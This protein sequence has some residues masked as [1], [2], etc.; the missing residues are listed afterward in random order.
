MKR[1]KGV[2]ILLILLFTACGIEK[3]KGKEKEIEKLK[4]K[5]ATNNYKYNLVIPQISNVQSEDISYFNLSLQENARLII[6]ELL[7]S[8]EDLKQSTPYEA[9]MSYEVKENSF[10]IT[11][12]LLKIYTYTGGAHGNTTL[13]TYNIGDKDLKL[14]NFETFF[15]ENAKSYF[16]LK[17][18]DAIA[19]RE[20]V[21]N[22]NGDEVIFFEE[23]EINIKN[24]VMYFEGDSVK[25]VFPL[26]DL[27]PYSS[28]MP[29]FKFSKDEIKKYM[30]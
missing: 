5:G 1:L 9:E 24:A 12:I 11:S 6:D 30:K 17:I 18:N 16:E 14:I 26:Y 4:Y 25:F 2:I 10:E 22:I 20:K 28:G 23:P 27:A 13:E 15:N 7:E 29:V 21:K 19:N 3:E 8:T